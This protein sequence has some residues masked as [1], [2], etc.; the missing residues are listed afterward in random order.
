MALNWRWCDK[1]GYYVTREK[2]RNFKVNIYNCNGLF[3]GLYEFK[4]E[5]KE[6]MYN[7][8]C[9]ALD[10]GHFKNELGLNKRFKSNI[11]KGFKWCFIK[12]KN[13]ANNKKIDLIIKELIKTDCKIEIKIKK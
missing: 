10:L 7:V 9:F 13:E 11:F 6:K 2:G 4:N 1:I 12:T 8:Q 3:I 5:N